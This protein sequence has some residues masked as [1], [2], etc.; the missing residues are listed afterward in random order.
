MLAQKAK[1]ELIEMYY[2]E[3]Q[4]KEKYKREYIEVK[5]KERDIED[6]AEKIMAIV[7]SV[8]T[9]LINFRTLYRLARELIKLVKGGKK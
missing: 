2:V 5:R 8:F 3:V 6:I 1:E 9:V 7:T 4:E